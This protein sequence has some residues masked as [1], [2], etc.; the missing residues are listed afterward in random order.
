MCRR[1]L[2][3]MVPEHLSW[4]DAAAWRGV[5]ST[6][7]GDG[8]LCPAGGPAWVPWSSP[9]V[10]SRVMACVYRAAS[11][12]GLHTRGTVTAGSSLTGAS[13]NRLAGGA[14]GWPG[15]SQT[16]TVTACQCRPSLKGASWPGENRCAWLSNVT[17]LE[18]SR[19]SLGG[20][21]RFMKPST[22]GH[23]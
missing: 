23:T 16:P 15:L 11:T 7:C 18:Y 1:V 17:L 8:W 22:L 2:G 5:G 4:S 19:L 21:G 20:G 13:W 10:L 6:S 12:P 14:A 9:C 3:S